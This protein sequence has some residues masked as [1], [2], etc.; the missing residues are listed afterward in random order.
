MLSE[1]SLDNKSQMNQWDDF[2][3]SHPESTPFHLST[4][5]RVIHEA[6]S[7]KPLLYVQ[8]D[9]DGNISGIAPFFLTKNPLLQTRLISIPFSDY[10]GPLCSDNGQA[11]IL[12]N[13]IVKKHKNQVRYFEVRTDLQDTGGLYPQLH[14]KRHVLHLSSNPQAIL[15]R[16]EKRTIQYS[17]RKALREGVVVTTENNPRGISEFFRLNK[18][19]RKK[20]GVPYQPMMFFQKLYDYIISKGTGRIMLASFDSTVI[21]ASLF[22]MLNDH[23]Y[24][25]YNA[26]DPAYLSRKT[27]NHL[28]TWQAIEQGC[29][30][31]YHFFDF[32]RTSI[33]DDGLLRY[34]ELW[35]ADSL[36]LPYYFFPNVKLT[37]T[38][39]GDSSL[40]RLV[41]K[42]W[43]SL[44]DGVAD[45]LAPKVYRYLA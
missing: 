38:Q 28:L 31:G 41:S 7:F 12:L 18:L 25:K 14:Y 34:K 39:E 23:I 33:H 3:H 9:N 36:D 29:I 6:Y 17:I 19:T 21:A 1:F 13:S 44:P 20:H 11:A 8:Q 32:G 30:E 35:G 22:L 40:Y 42:V 16:I 15:K 37:K 24:Y 27:P 10:G 5:I 4:W 45:W 43:R 26:S 2:V